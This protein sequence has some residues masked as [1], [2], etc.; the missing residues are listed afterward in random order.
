MLDSYVALV[1]AWP[2]PMAMLQFALLGTF[3]DLLAS[4]L[5]AR[6]VHWPF[7]A[8]VLALKLGKWALLAV[9]IKLAFVGFAGFTD[10]LAAQGWL[11]DAPWLRAL[12]TSV[13]I[14]LQFGPLLVLGH[15][16]LNNRITGQRGWAGI[17]RSLWSL[18][19]FWVPAHALTFASPADY[20]IGLAALWSCVLGL[21]LG[22]H[23]RPPQSSSTL[24]T[25]RAK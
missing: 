22:L 23:T 25:E 6:R 18:L 20:R 17:D 2:L 5:A 10:A 7:D 13:A 3:G 19:W 21:I 15:R 16:W 24:A 1:R 9:P 12:A 8:R 11:L 14:N 4:W